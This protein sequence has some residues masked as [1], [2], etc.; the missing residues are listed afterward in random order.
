MPLHIDVITS[1]FEKRKAKNPR[2]SL[3]AF[4]SF[5]ELHPSAL[6]RIL[7]SKQLL[8]PRA[9]LM[10]SRKLHLDRDVQRK[11]LRSIIL[12]RKDFE[13]TKLGA[14]VG[15]PR[16]RPEPVRISDGVDPRVTSVQCLAILQLTQSESFV[17]S[18]EWIADQLKSSR[19][20]VQESVELLLRTGLLKEKDGKWSAIS[21]HVTTG[22]LT[23]TSAARRALQKEILEKAI[24]ALEIP[25]AERAHF[26]MTMMIDP[27]KVSIARER[28]IEFIESLADELETGSRRAVYQLGVQLFPVSTKQT[29]R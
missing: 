24:S 12:A 26:G 13:S 21:E 17:S 15:A 29:P 19:E 25:L 23:E 5:L 18:V 3:R 6:S 22:D 28:I 2:Y 9:G 4:A 20:T 27:D 11:F 1:E 8:S 10:V 7:S 16:L 14:S